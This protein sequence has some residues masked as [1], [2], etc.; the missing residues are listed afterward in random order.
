MI[1]YV[2][3][4]NISSHVYNIICDDQF[5]TVDFI[6]FGL[7]ETAMCKEVSC[8]LR[9]HRREGWVLKAIQRD[10]WG[11][12]KFPK[13]DGEKCYLTRLGLTTKFSAIFVC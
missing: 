12:R 1:F 3:H 6:N 8:I 9:H 5:I 10:R 11:G 13:T 7:S 4:L 2:F